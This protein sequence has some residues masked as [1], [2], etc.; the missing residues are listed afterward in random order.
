[1]YTLSHG[2][3]THK[4]KTSRVTCSD[5]RNDISRRPCLELRCASKR[6]RT[7]IAESHSY[8][9]PDEC[10]YS[11]TKFR[12]I[13]TQKTWPCSMFL[14]CNG[15]AGT[16]CRCRTPEVCV[17]VSVWRRGWFHRCTQH[18]CSPGSH[19]YMREHKRRTLK[20]SQSPIWESSAMK[21]DC[22]CTALMAVCMYSMGG[23]RI[24]IA[25]MFC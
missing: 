8:G 23:C 7:Y 16:Y 18:Y 12:R 6:H 5:I 14:S 17:F 13:L 21:S 10:V 24:G 4:L 19:M 15:V 1:M 3:Y 20:Y 9:C 11:C 2:I 22:F 25:W